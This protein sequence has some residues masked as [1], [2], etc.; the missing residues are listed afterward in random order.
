M[1]LTPFE[2]D[3]CGCHKLKGDGNT[4]LAFKFDFQELV[5]VLR[6]KEAPGTTITLTITGNLKEEFGGTPFQGQDCIRVSK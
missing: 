3:L 6:L 2:G 5:Q 4:D 1:R